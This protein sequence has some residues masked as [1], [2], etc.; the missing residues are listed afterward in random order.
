ME[1]TASCMLVVIGATPEGRKELVGFQVGE[2]ESA[3]RLRGSADPRGFANQMKGLLAFH[4][5]SCS[6]I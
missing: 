6:S 5:G 3:P 4:G 2:R 1:D